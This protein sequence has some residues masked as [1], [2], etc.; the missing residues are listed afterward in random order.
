MSLRLSPEEHIDRKVLLAVTAAI[1][2]IEA[3]S[4]AIEGYDI[5]KDDAELLASA[6]GDLWSILE[7]NGYTIDSDTNRLRRATLDN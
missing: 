1:R 4:G 7:T 6:L 5:G 2:N 3:I